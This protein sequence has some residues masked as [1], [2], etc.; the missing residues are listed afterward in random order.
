MLTT[1]CRWALPAFVSGMIA[2]R[3]LAET[4][5]ADLNR[6]IRPYSPQRIV[7]LDIGETFVFKLKDGTERKIRVVSVEEHRDSVVKLMRRADVR[8]EI[9]G[10][11]LDLVCMPYVMPTRTAGLR[12]QADTTSGWGNISK[13]VQ[14][15]IWDAADS[16]VD[17]KKFGNPLREL[18]ML[19]QG[20]QCYNEPVHLGLGDDDPAGQRFYHDY[21]FDQAGFEGR[22]VVF[23]AVEG[24]IAKFW[25]SREDLCSV[26]V[27]D[28]NGL[29]WEHGHLK[30]VEPD[31]VL[32]AR[33]QRGQKLGILGKT[34][35]S[36]NFA[37][38]H[39]G[40]YLT[41]ADLESDN[42]DTRLNLYPWLVFAYR[43]SHGDEL[44]AV[45][46]PH[47]ILLTGEKAS[48]DG[49]NS[50]DCSARKIVE[51]RWVFPDT[52]TVKKPRAEKVFDKPGAYV[53]ALWLKDD[54]GFEDVD[55]CQVKVYSR[56]NPEKAMPHIF[57][58]YY[59]TRDIQPDQTVIFRFWYQG[60]GG[61]PVQVEFDDG[62]RVTDYQSYTELRHAFKT[63]GVHVVTAHCEADGKPITQKL[64]VIVQPSRKP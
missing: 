47:Q 7:G 51:Y 24:T 45:A 53:V 4:P 57:M 63:P 29:N 62:T 2:A 59:P 36:G 8:V 18:R 22:E 6:L 27:Q 23:S 33:V 52:E 61:G 42:R 3:L 35:P 46:R 26:I 21:G 56:L 17:I 37:H 5:E 49:S 54:K 64:K 28:A 31:I 38:T 30:S 55:F 25:P 43:Q 32:N 34:G 11:P 41:M 16:I 14:L 40:T 58:T 20:T 12:I 60:D 19:S 39:L 15:S 1:L 9:D 13:K 44:V 50:W 48:F 10:Q